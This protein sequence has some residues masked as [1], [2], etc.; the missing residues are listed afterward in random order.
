MA[1]LENTTCF[2]NWMPAEKQKHQVTKKK[3][4]ESIRSFLFDKLGQ[5]LGHNVTRQRHWFF[6]PFFSWMIILIVLISDSPSF[7]NSLS[8]P[9]GNGGTTHQD[10]NE[11]GM[12]VTTF[13]KSTVKSNF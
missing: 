1:W 4:K 3:K 8:V 2:V 13:Y 12:C 11:K 9:N 10:I 5:F 7:G 6:F